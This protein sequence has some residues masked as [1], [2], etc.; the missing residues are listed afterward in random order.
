[1][2]NTSPNP[3]Q[4][5]EPKTANALLVKEFYALDPPEKLAQLLSTADNLKHQLDA[6]RPLKEKE[7]LW[8]GLQE[9]LRAEWTY[10]S[11]AIEGSTLTLGE[12]IFFLQYGLTVEGKPFK[13]FLDARNHSEAIELLYE[14]I[15]DERPI[16]ESL[17]KELNALLVAGITYTKAIDQFGQP[18]RR[19]ATP[20]KY[21]TLPNTVLKPDG[22]IYE[23]VSP[24]HVPDEMGYLCQW[25]DTHLNQLHP[26]ITS[27]V[28]HY[29]FVRIHPFDDGNGRG[30]RILMNMIL[31]KHKYPPAIIKMEHRRK[32]LDYLEAAN[33]GDLNPFI[34]FV[35]KSLINTEATML[36]V[37]EGN[38]NEQTSQPP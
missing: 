37:L 4:P 38:G 13:D 33:Q 34:E 23:Y 27:A 16:S 8:S 28:A 29:N 19:P 10:H 21:K 6:Y 5:D 15:R 1:M 17:I 24:T 7:H 32:Y 36:K 18:T 2:L 31:L 26:V 11:N 22:T 9:K 20:G 30:A 25:I 35:T 3:N 12:T 14:F